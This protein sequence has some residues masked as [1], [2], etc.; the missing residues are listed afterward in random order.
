MYKKMA[1]FFDD[2]FSQQEEEFIQKIIKSFDGFKNSTL[3]QSQI[4]E[5]KSKGKG[6][7]GKLIESTIKHEFFKQNSDYDKNLSSEPYLKH[8][9][10]KTDLQYYKN[11][12][13][14]DLQIK[15]I[16]LTR[17]NKKEIELIKEKFDP[18]QKTKR[19]IKLSKSDFKKY[20]LFFEKCSTLTLFIVY[21]IDKKNNYFNFQF[22]FLTK[23]KLLEFF[24]QKP[25]ENKK[26]SLYHYNR[27]SIN[28]LG[29]TVKKLKTLVSIKIPIDNTKKHIYQN[30]LKTNLNLQY[31]KIIQEI[32]KNNNFRDEFFKKT[33][34]TTNMSYL[35]ENGFLVE[36]LIS[37]YLYE[38]KNI[39]NLSLSQSNIK[40]I[41]NIPVDFIIDNNFFQLKTINLDQKQK[42]T[43]KKKKKKKKN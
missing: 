18:D 34:T 11:D 28:F 4:L 6:E 12:Y 2:E 30:E 8:Y 43:Q 9:Y 39:K 36:S 38:N 16:K 10:P 41:T 17:F 1:E 31:L 24:L 22:F 27:S 26:V 14:N 37:K 32:L 3:F 33:K 25:E 20:E 15:T 42:T 19:R 35:G 5:A 29:P 23:K 13:K 40:H 21:E 7:V